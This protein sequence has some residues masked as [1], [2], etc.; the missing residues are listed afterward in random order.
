MKRTSPYA[1]GF[2]YVLSNPAMPGR[3]KVG[4]TDRTGEIRADELYTTGV[5]EPYR[6]EF[7]AVTSRPG[8]VEQAAHRLLD[9][10]RPNPRREFFT[11]PVAEAV[12]AVREALKTANGIWP[13][14]LEQ[15]VVRLRRGDRLAVTCRGGELFT[16]LSYR[17]IVSQRPDEFDVW[18]APSDGDTV[19]FMATED[20]GHVAG[21]SA[22]DPGAEQDPVPCLD[23][24]GKVLNMTMIG[25]ECLVPGDRLIWLGTP[26]RRG[27]VIIEAEAYCQVVCRTWQPRFAAVGA[28]TYPVLFN[29]PDMGD[30]SADYREIWLTSTRMA[31]R[32]PR[33]R[34][35]AP[36]KR[37]PGD[38][39]AERATNPPDPEFW[40]PQLDARRRNRSQSTV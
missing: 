20:P 29:D 17:S 28:V 30:L 6:V 24:N 13:W 37:Y 27:C 18:H 9:A 12:H 31:M 32:L 19:E 34:S 33:P 36:R 5:P 14:T 38:G 25:R 26:A 8:E 3:V 1:M 11:V 22:G 35:W 39:W 40:L 23:R 16:L 15:D 2:V 4:R 7:R 21:F 10:Q